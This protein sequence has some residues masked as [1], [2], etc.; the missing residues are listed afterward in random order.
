MM[1]G[2]ELGAIRGHR[3]WRYK[4]NDRSV[5]LYSYVADICWPFVDELVAPYLDSHDTKIATG[6]YS[7]KTIRDMIDRSRWRYIRASGDKYVTDDL[8]GLIRSCRSADADGLAF[9]EIDMWGVVYE[10]EYGY[11]A[12]CVRPVRL[13][14]TIGHNADKALKQLRADYYCL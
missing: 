5:R 13:H 10:Y 2:F 1:S 4:F 3:Y 9:G 7:Y 11:R 8:D 6:I 14:Q 12:E